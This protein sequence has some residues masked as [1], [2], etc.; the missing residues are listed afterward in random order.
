MSDFFG[1]S[2]G[3]SQ[4]LNITAATVVKAVPGRIQRVQVLAAGSA[5]G[6]VYDAAAAAGNG[7]AN[8]VGIIPNAIGS[9]LIDMPCAAGI[10]VVPGAGQT[11]AVSY[12]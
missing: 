8:Q 9:Y 3:R 2:Q 12:D 1:V 5:S 6:A 4:A 7:A 10:V 11:L